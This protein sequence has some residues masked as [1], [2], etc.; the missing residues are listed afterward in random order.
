[1]CGDTLAGDVVA[2]DA[3]MT[4]L[5]GGPAKDSNSLLPGGSPGVQ[6]LLNLVE[7]NGTVTVRT[8]DYSW[9][10]SVVAGDGMYPFSSQGYVDVITGQ[11]GNLYCAFYDDRLVTGYVD[12]KS[13]YVRKSVD[14]GATWENIDGGATGFALAYLGGLDARPSVEVWET[15]PGNYRIAV[16]VSAGDE[17]LS[18]Y[19]VVILW[20]ELGSGNDWSSYFLGNSSYDYAL[21]R[22]KAIPRPSN[23]S[24]SRLI[25]AFVLTQYGY[26]LS[27]Y[28]DTDAASFGS[29]AAFISD[30]DAWEMWRPDMEYD[31]ENDRLFCVYSMSEYN[32]PN[33]LAKTLVALS[34]DRSLSWYL[35]IFSIAPSGWN[36]CAEAEAALSANP[37]QT[38]STLM[39]VYSAQ[40]TIGDT[41]HIHYTYQY[42]NA[43]VESGGTWDIDPVGH[44]VFRGTVYS[45]TDG[46]NTMPAIWA[47]DRLTIGG[48]RIALL[49]ETS[50]SS[51]RMVYTESTFDQPA[52]WMVP[53]EVSAPGAD[54]ARQGTGTGV[55]SGVAVGSGVYADTRIVVWPDYRNGADSGIYCAR[56]PDTAVTPTPIPTQA[57]TET[58]A[59]TVSPTP[60]PPPI[61]ATGPAGLILLLAGVSLLLG[62]I[63]R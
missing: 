6:Q 36:I 16:A 47:D 7:E 44:P 12:H 59:P 33:H 3:A 41:F 5:I 24:R 62:L 50:T 8:S 4:R 11:D 32:D 2:G 58:P 31:A 38:D 34:P 46:D 26:Y 57:P 45:D 63:R 28:S 40:Q 48:F 22:L 29:S 51:S 14:G 52:V 19:D 61:P 20:K 18:S 43:I 39:V 15:T 42:L 23:P 56:Y 17:T 9:I 21:P 53:D 25:T 1:M 10:E 27:V 30:I 13:V 60:P 54:P 37:L 49:D 55:S 35:D